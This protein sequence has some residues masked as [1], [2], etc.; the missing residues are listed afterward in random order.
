MVLGSEERNGDDVMRSTSKSGLLPRRNFLKSAAVVGAA[1]LSVPALSGAAQQS[2]HAVLPPPRTDA[3]ET[4]AVPQPVEGLTFERSGSDHIVDVFKSIGFEYAPFVSGNDFAALQESLTNYGGNQSPQLLTVLHEEAAVAVA[5]GYYKAEGKPLITLCKG[6]V[7]ALHASMAIYNASYD[8][9]PVYV[10]LG[11]HAKDSLPVMVKCVVRPRSLE[12]FATEAVKAYKIAMTPPYGPVVVVC[13]MAL[14][15]RGISPDLK[16]PIPK[17]TLPTIP[18]ADSGS[19]AEVAR[20]LVAANNP[21][22]IADK[23]RTGAS[24]PLLVELAETLQAKVV[25]LQGLRT[26]FPS[27][28]PLQRWRDSLADVDLVL[29]LET[30]NFAGIVR[31]VMGIETTNFPNVNV[32]P[33]SRPTQAK[34]ITITAGDFAT[35]PQHSVDMVV[36]ADAEATLPSLIEAVKRLIT[37]DRRVLY[38]TR[39]TKFA[40]EK[41]AELKSVRLRASYGWDATPIS[42]SRVAAELAELVRDEDWVLV[43]G[44]W[45]FNEEMEGSFWNFDKPYRT[46]GTTGGGGLGNGMPSAVGAALAHKKHGRLCVNSQKDGDFMFCP[47]PLWVAAKY[48]IPLLTVMKNNGGYHQEVMEVQRWCNRMNRGIDRA[49]IGN[50]FGHPNIDYAKLAQSFGVYGE[51]PVANPNDLG[52]ALK[53]ALAVVKRGEPALVDVITQ[54]R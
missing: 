1:A 36:S 45:V 38:Q 2:P 48:Q 15:E 37:S 3:E 40:E 54:G 46:T 44:G 30:S 19:V 53:R 23:L 10:V 49:S 25:S 51:G 47:Q 28:H 52:P 21:V 16:L 41:A 6:D 43:G 39:G 33:S 7:G 9:V 12:E 18:M 34:M 24:M 5:H 17:V 8:R 22:I 20:L 4:N 13:D 50:E 29:G 26:N 14:T 11:G 27:R 35:T 32:T 31:I 42:N